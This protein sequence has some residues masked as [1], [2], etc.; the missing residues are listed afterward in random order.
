MS[1]IKQYNYIQNYQRKLIYLNILFSMTAASFLMMKLSSVYSQI[2]PYANVLELVIAGG[3]ISHLLGK[4]SGRIIFRKI[5][6]TRVVFLINES[7]FLLSSAFAFYFY[8]QPAETNAEAVLSRFIFSPVLY[9]AAALS[10][11][12]FLGIKN[13]YF[14]KASCGKFFD[15]KKGT[16]AYMGFFIFG[17]ASGILIY[18]FVPSTISKLAAMS[19]LGFSI[20]PALFIS[21][22]YQPEDI[23][24]KDVF[25]GDSPQ[26]EPDKDEIFFNFLNFSSIAIYLF[27]GAL[28]FM[29]YY[30]ESTSSAF[31]FLCTSVLSIL[32]GYVLS[33]FSRV[34]SWYIYSE[35]LYPVFFFVFFI[36]ISRFGNEIPVFKSLFFFVPIGLLFG[37]TLCHSL[38]SILKSSDQSRAHHIIGTSFFALPACI[39]SAIMFIPFT[40]FSYFL[41]FYIVA[42]VNIILPGIYI[43]Q[44]KIPEYKKFIFFITLIILIPTFIFLHRNFS[45]PF[46]SELF[47]KHSNADLFRP[48]APGESVVSSNGKIVIKT[49]GYARNSMERAVLAAHILSSGEKTLILSGF[50]QFFGIKSFNYFR[51]GRI[52][53]YVPGRFVDFNRPPVSGQNGPA[54]KSG[55]LLFK[56]ATSKDRFDLILDIPNLFDITENRYRFSLPVISLIKK[57]IND[58]GIYAVIIPSAKE[59]SRERCAIYGILGKLFSNHSAFVS[60]DSILIMASD[61]K[62]SLTFGRKSLEKLSTAIDAE[63]LFYEDVHFL[64]KMMSIDLKNQTINP[65]ESSAR[66]DSFTDLLYSLYFS[67]NASYTGM[68]SEAELQTYLSQKI[69]KHKDILLPLK[70]AEK[71]ESRFEFDKEMQLLFS[72]KKFQLGYEIFSV[73][74]ENTLAAKEKIYI[75]EAEIFEKEKKWEDARNL[76]K[77]VLV[78]NERNFDANC[79][80][81]LIAITVQ[82]ID[83]AFS[84]FSKALAINPSDSLVNYQM[85]IMLMSRGEYQKALEY[86]LKAIE[87][88]NQETKTVFFT[89]FCYENIGDLLKAETYYKQA[90]LLDPQDTDIKTAVERIAKK[91]EAERNKWKEEVRDN[92]LESEKDVNFPLPINESA[93]KQRLSEKE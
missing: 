53:S 39:F 19:I 71:F 48:E 31:I 2:F 67:D 21:L 77:A 18:Y 33:S 61:S 45:I 7:L 82:D 80:L 1:E 90:F 20:V 56:L 37:F 22:K 47:L 62:D 32:T 46:G 9:A 51:E 59:Y 27:L 8:C 60:E 24:A 14:L 17:L 35:I 69:S 75:K 65:D 76:Y 50:S 57:K 63:K 3:L 44:R 85:G 93:L 38:K 28:A 64:S 70:E 55:D 12:F 23:F 5:Q 13:N 79:K 89:G 92:Q 83:S 25:A 34:R 74:L 11:P 42:A 36:M 43:A 4:F 72:L 81:G 16:A 15:E 87:L 54:V 40:S 52:F 29:R 86:L 84:Y 91:I 41:L 68:I 10:V 26:N 66:G 6:S 78:L 73:Y 30:G 88:N 49:S 58:N